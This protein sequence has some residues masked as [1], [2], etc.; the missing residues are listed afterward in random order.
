MRPYFQRSSEKRKEI[1]N[2][3]PEWSQMAEV[4]SS[5]QDQRAGRQHWREGSSQPYWEP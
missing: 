3:W 1:T 5:A 2:H 4:R